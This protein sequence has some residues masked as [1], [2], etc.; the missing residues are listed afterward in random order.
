MSEL[1]KKP[2][3]ASYKRKAK[4]KEERHQNVIKHTKNIETFFSKTKSDDSE[5]SN[6][7]IIHSVS[8]TDPVQCE[9]Y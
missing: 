6:A 9:T 1:K 4:E 3:G 5:L 7:I 8:A 2:S